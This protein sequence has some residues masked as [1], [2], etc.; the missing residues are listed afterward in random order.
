M[1][2]IVAR[3]EGNGGGT[4]GSVDGDCGREWWCGGS[5]DE[6]RG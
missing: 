6:V 5:N 4:G 2:E 3:G 1:V